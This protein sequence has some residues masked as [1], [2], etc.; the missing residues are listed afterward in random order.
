MFSI[1]TDALPE[2][3]SVGEV[4]FGVNTDFRVWLRILSDRMQSPNLRNRLEIA[5]ALCSNF[6]ELILQDPCRVAPVEGSL[7]IRDAVS[8]E[9]P[10][11]NYDTMLRGIVFITVRFNEITKY[12]IFSTFIVWD[13]SQEHRIH[14]LYLT[15]LYNILFN[16]NHL[17]V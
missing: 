7:E 5:R 9:L 4:V 11:L 12:S 10:Q 13:N 1:L 8:I 17:N 3:I 15:T 14:L 2:F 16:I 6:F